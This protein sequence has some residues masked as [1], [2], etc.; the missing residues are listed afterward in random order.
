MHILKVSNV[1]NTPAMGDMDY[2][3]VTVRASSFD[4]LMD[5]LLG[6]ELFRM[7]ARTFRPRPFAGIS[8][9]TYLFDGSAACHLLD[10]TGADC[11]LLPGGF[12]WAQAGKGLV[13]AAFPEKTGVVSRGIQLLVNIPAKR[14]QSEP[15]IALYG[16]APGSAYGGVYTRM[17]MDSADFNFMYMR[18]ARSE[19]TT[20]RLPVGWNATIHLLAGAVRI[21][22]DVGGTEL[23]AGTTVALGQSSVA[24]RLV[25][26]AHE[27]SEVLL[28]SGAPI[29]EP[30]FGSETMSMASAE[31]LEKALADYEE[32][33]MGFITLTA[34]KWQIIPPT[35]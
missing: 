31:A 9:L 21:Q 25:V 33:K 11:L 17:V 7:R 16:A 3:V 28:F 23:R 10:T 27:R 4:G 34:G 20:Y 19:S 24:E 13:R 8:I 32:G 30:S 35:K 6:F 15:L 1:V 2:S 26:E 14:K 5:P 18:I 22:T 29:R 12:V